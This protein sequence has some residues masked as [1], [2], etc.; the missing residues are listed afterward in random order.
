[1]IAIEKLTMRLAAAAALVTLFAP[2]RAQDGAFQDEKKPEAGDKKEASKDGDEA[3]AKKKEEKKDRWFAVTGGD[4]HTGLGEVLKG[5]TVLSKNGKIEKIGYD[6]DLPPDTQ[7]LDVRG[8]SVYPGLVAIQSQGLFGNAASDFDDTIDPFNYRMVLG[9][10]A[11]ITTSGV[12]SSAV[13]LKRF[14][15][16]GATLAEKVF[17][18]F[19]W[20]GS[21]PRQKGE[22]REKFKA[23][24]AYLREYREWE[25]KVKEQKDLPEPAKKSVDNSVL[26]VLKG[27]T[28]AKFLASDRDDLLGIAR[29]AQ[30][31]AFRPVIEGCMEGWTVADELGRAGARAI[32]TP[33]DRRTKD[34]RQAREG[35][36]SIENAAILHKAGVQVA[37]VPA[38]E[39][40]D[41]GGIVG[42]DIMHL[43]IEADFGVRGGLTD[44]AALEAITIVPARILGVGHRVGSLEVGK[45]CDLIVTDGDLLHYKTFVQWSVVDGRVVYD[46][47]KELFFAHIRPRADQPA[48]RKLDA[49]E[50]PTKPEAAAKE[51]DEAS[52]EKKDDEKKDEKKDDE[53]KPDEPKDGEKKGDEERD[54]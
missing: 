13:K 38:T 52:D 28:S 27:E 37:I 7:E 34:E 18:T 20:S 25:R 40:V 14:A 23:A 32:L 8:L 42:R 15:V 17:S 2:A 41:L 33:R 6:L 1:M 49:G 22:L 19:S 54:G 10:A 9:L 3:A 44:R 5:A 51:G 53:P 29:L 47:Q 12:G 11:G 26:A 21:A 46:K 50:T 16:D 31:F 24:T 35:G 48:E 39:G 36:S 4:V 30:E 45:D 43:T